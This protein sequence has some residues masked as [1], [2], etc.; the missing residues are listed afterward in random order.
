MFGLSQYKAA[1]KIVE[2]FRLPIEVTENK[3]LSTKEKERIRRE[4]AERER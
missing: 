1:L 2:D 4:R 3:E